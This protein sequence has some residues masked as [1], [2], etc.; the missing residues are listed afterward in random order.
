MQGSGY[1]TFNL[2][3]PADSVELQLFALSGK[4]VDQ[5]AATPR[6]G[7]NQIE[8]RPAADLAN[9]TYLY[10]LRVDSSGATGSGRSAGEISALQ[11]MR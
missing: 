5:I 4:M 6:P 2:F 9:G 8:W 3:N 10:R 11:I 1:F 7:Y